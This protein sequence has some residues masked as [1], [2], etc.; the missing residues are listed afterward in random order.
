MTQLAIITSFLGAIRNRYISYQD[1]RSLEEKLSLAASVDNIAGVE[2]CYPQD[3]ANPELLKELLQQHRLGVSAINFRSRRTGQWMR[4]SF[5]SHLANE[6][7]DVVDDLKKAMDAAVD[8]RL[9][10]DLPL[11]P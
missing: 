7:R 3:F 10:P 2:L 4:G 9:Q 11:A 5:S 8:T 1:E 6:R